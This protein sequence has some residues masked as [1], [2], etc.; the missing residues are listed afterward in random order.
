LAA[1]LVAWLAGVL[2]AQVVA[3][4]PASAH[5][6]LVASTPGNGERLVEAPDEVVL[7]FT[8]SV[9]LLAGG[10]QLLDADGNRVDT[11]QPVAEGTTVRWAMPANLGDGA[12]LVN[13]RVVSGDSHPVAGAFSF[14]VGVAPQVVNQTPIVTAA[15][16]PITGAR[17]AGYLGFTLIAGVITF[18]SLCWPGGRGQKR[19]QTLLRAGLAIAAASTVL[20]LL[21]HGPYATGQP[22][23]RLAAV[24]LLAETSHTGFGAW[25]QLRLYL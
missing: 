17:L 25:T 19:M 8:E 15:P 24:D 14:G 16:W 23:T 9:G 10:L 13:W 18:T 6:E 12:Y 22:L 20:G 5:A 1:A 2:L 3:A 11:P 21:L 4:G 7:E